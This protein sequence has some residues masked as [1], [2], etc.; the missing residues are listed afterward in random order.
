MKNNVERCRGCLTK[1][2]CSY[3]HV[4]PMRRC[5]QKSNLKVVGPWHLGKP[6]LQNYYKYISTCWLTCYH[7]IRRTGSAHAITFHCLKRFITRNIPAI[8]NRSLTNDFD[9]GF[10]RTI[11]KSLVK[12]TNFACKTNEFRLYFDK[13]NRSF[14]SDFDERI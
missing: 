9:E 8:E 2:T 5:N 14:T 10:W 13:R 6:Y 11:L 3:L 1:L 7:H 4:G 12:R